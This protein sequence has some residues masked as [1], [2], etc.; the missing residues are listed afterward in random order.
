MLGSLGVP[1]IIFIVVLALLIFGPKRLPEIGRTVGKGLSEF[2]RASAEIQRT[3]NAELALEEDP[4]PVQYPRRVSLVEPEGEA[5]ASR[6]PPAG[7]LA[8]GG[9]IG[10]DELDEP[11]QLPYQVA[12]V[13]DPVDETLDPEGAPP[14]PQ[15]RAGEPSP[16][17]PA[18]V[19]PS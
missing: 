13:V 5:P 9:T 15:E 16:V 11:G 6:T 18:P 17:S 3:I 19:E 10:D 14:T 12:D 7:A 2:R 8:R 1:E 4:R